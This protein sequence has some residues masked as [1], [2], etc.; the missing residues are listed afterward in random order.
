MCRCAERRAALAQAADGVRRVDPAAVAAAM[1]FIASST[2]G[3]LSMAARATV[4]RGRA[5]A[6]LAK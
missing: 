3:D 5:L 4:A 1:A 2:V 6:R